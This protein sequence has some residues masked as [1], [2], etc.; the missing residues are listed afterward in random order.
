M[1][2][3]DWAA[4]ITEG[5]LAVAEQIDRGDAGGS[6]V[7]A[8][9]AMRELVDHPGLTPSARVIEELDTATGQVENKET[10][11]M[12]RVQSQVDSARA[13]Q[14]PAIVQPDAMEPGAVQPSP[15][16]SQATPFEDAPDAGRASIASLIEEAN[17]QKAS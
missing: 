4:S 12:D 11:V 5:T 17:G 7:S 6:Y 16:E 9:E 8:V 13:A 2:L 1:A 3:R 10:N 15:F 14:P